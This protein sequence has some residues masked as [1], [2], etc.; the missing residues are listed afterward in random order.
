M[1]IIKESLDSKVLGCNVQVDT[2]YGEYPLEL[3]AIIKSSKLANYNSGEIKFPALKLYPEAKYTDIIHQNIFSF[4]KLLISKKTYR[5]L[6]GFRL[7]DHQVF[8]CKL[9]RGKDIQEY[10]IINLLIDRADELIDWDQSVCVRWK[11]FGH[12]DLGRIRIQSRDE[13]IEHTRIRMNSTEPLE[14]RVSALLKTLVLKSGIINLDFFYLGSPALGHYMSAK[15]VE[16]IKGSDLTGFVF[17]S[18]QERNDRIGSVQ[19]WP[20]YGS[21]KPGD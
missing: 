15:L 21:K 12:L 10:Y 18:I 4:P 1:Y 9:Y 13:F 11:S 16:Y 14:E 3:R 20:N 8:S 6:S 2:I 17:E 5:Y 19:P 7:D